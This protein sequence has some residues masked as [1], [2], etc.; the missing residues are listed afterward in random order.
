MYKAAYQYES[1]DASSL[2]FQEN[3]RFTVMDTSNEF[4]WLV[5]NGNGQVG[6]VPANY[7]EKDDVST[8]FYNSAVV[9][10]ILKR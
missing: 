4:W 2:S 9:T 10:A 5:Q 1:Q 6:Y 7:L 3:D 8:F